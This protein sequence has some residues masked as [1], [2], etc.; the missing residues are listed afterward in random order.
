MIS[1]AGE[2]RRVFLCRTQ[3]DG[4]LFVLA[5][6]RFAVAEQRKAFLGGD[7]RPPRFVE[8]FAMALSLSGNTAAGRPRTEPAGRCSAS[9]I[10]YSERWPTQR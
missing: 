10:V 4:D 2:H 5:L 9:F 3:A 8:S 1:P 6:G 7:D